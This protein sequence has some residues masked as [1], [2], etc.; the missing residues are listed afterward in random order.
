MKAKLLTVKNFI[1]DME[2]MKEAAAVIRGGGTVIFPT[3]TVYG[4]GADGLNPSAAEKIYRAKGRPSDNP[5]ILHIS[6]IDMLDTIVTDVSQKAMQLA[7]KFWPGP[8][9]M[10]LKKKSN[11]PYQTTGGLDTVGV[12]M[13]SNAIARE[14]IRFSETPIAA[15]SANL[16]GKPSITLWE[17]A[18]EEMGDR[19]DVILLSEPSEI[20][21]EST[22]IDMTEEIPLILRLG[23]IV[24]SEIEK[25]IGKIELDKTILGEQDIPKA[26]GMKYR[27]YSPEAEVYIVSGK[28]KT[29]K[30]I[31]QYE[32]MISENPVIFALEQKRQ[33]YEGKNFFSLGKDTLEA[34]RVLFSYLRKADKEGYGVILMEDV[35]FDE[36]GQAV[37]NRACKAADGK[38]I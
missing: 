23:R 30:I 13:P 3:E 11:V 7:E 19:V 5:L 4:L 1:R 8:L 6:D 21:L 33:D 34:A 18:V 12:R 25:V 28:E 29:E 31:A 16:S 15:P 36:V 22:I 10:I 27:H 20:G 2:K 26:P 9:T 24:P 37:M 32:K 35:S 38:I 17:Q 14:L